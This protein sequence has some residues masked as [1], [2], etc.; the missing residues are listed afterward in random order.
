MEWTAVMLGVL[1]AADFCVILADCA[2]GLAAYWVDFGYSVV[3]VM[4]GGF[5]DPKT[6]TA[7]FVFYDSCSS[8]GTNLFCLADAAHSLHGVV[9]H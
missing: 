5:L 1:L 9:R 8:L 2:S 4:C 3:C 6:A 7:A